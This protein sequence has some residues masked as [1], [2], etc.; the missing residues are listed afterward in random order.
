MENLAHTLVGAALA[1]AGL[2]RLS[3]LAMPTALIAAN[4]PDIDVVGGFWG[5]LAGLDLHRGI[6]HSFVGIACEAPLL[7][8]MMVGW[9]RLSRRADAAGAPARFAGLFVVALCGLLS[10]L[11][12]DYTNSY[13]VRPWL[14][15]DG[16]W[17]YGDLVFI[18]D[19]L[20]WLILGGA[21][22][23]AARGRRALVGWSVLGLLLS[24]AVLRVRLVPLPLQ[25]VWCAALAS[26]VVTRWRWRLP[27]TAAGRIALVGVLA[28][29][30]ALAVVH[31]RALAVARAS[32]PAGEV[33]V[34]PAL[35]DP[36]H[37]RAYAATADALYL[38]EV[39]VASDAV[40]THWQTIERRLDLPEVRRASVT[41]PG[42][43]LTNFAR[44]LVADVVRSGAAPV[45]VL[46]DVRFAQPGRPSWASVRI[47]VDGITV[48]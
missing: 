32:A 4:L 39:S 43:V 33:T 17:V 7:A 37:W 31:H 2:D 34:L 21:L 14:P 30:S 12:L 38:R 41:Y 44:F 16:H 9:D 36:F 26:I 25:V 28:Y 20:L 18:V 13:G 24:V 46:T 3:P 45:V 48:R 15:F 6:T 5:E 40:P 29:W 19:P 8:L 35:A 11:L 27:S 23:L 1:R 47:P 22:A 10:H 42:A